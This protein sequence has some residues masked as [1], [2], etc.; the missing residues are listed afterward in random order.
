MS[1]K[2][3]RITRRALLRAAG[4]SAIG[5]AVLWPFRH[6]LVS[7]ASA[8]N[9]GPR[10]RFVVA[11]SPNGTIFDQWVPTGTGTSFTLGRILSPLERHRA[12]LTVISGLGIHTA[13]QG[14]GDEH[15]RGVSHVVTAMPLL[16]GGMATGCNSCP[17]V[18][19][20]SG[21]SIDQVVA[22]TIGQDTRLRS[23]EL[24]VANGDRESVKTRL[25]YRG[26]SE[27]LPPESDPWAA[28]SRLFGDLA[29]PA[30]A[31]ARLASRRSL[32]DHNVSDFARVSAGLAAADRPLLD[33][34]LETIRELEMRLAAPGPQGPACAA[35][36]LGDPVTNLQ[37]ADDYPRLVG[38]TSDI[39]TMALACGL[40]NVGTILWNHSV[41]E[42]L[43]PSLGINDPHHTL[44]HRPDDD[45]AA[46]ESLVQ[47][48]N[49]YAERFAQL[50]DR[51]LAVEEPLPTGEVR[52]L[53]DSTLVVWV[54]ELGKGNI[55]SFT[56][57]PFVVLGNVPNVDGTP[58][59]TTSQH[60]ATSDAAH[61]DFW[62]SVLNAMG[63]PR[64][65]FGLPA[66]CNGP[67][68]GLTA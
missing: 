35:P 9:Q 53:L 52:S 56:N 68:P 22:D 58:H 34:H 50:G 16:P 66:Y 26:A 4:G 2:K 18:S 63:D 5:A 32:L 51:L 46:Q 38:L 8:D 13:M 17:P 67:L 25:A 48:N 61:G 29:D 64:T 7:R 39:M 59:F 1:E 60:V 6:L 10:K 20:A 40:T 15:Q 62:V 23:L 31:A 33:R 37:S 12:R 44:S 49:W 41:G 45:A 55:H 27:P 36:T 65:V 11:F 30:A 3:E 14:P 47:I 57:V 43:F 54:N 28:W 42:Q 19:W 21:P 24:G